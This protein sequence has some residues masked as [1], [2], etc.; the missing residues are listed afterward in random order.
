MGRFMRSVRHRCQLKPR[1]TRVVPTHST[2]L[3]QF[4]NHPLLTK[5]VEATIRDSGL[6]SV[7]EQLNN[8][9]SAQIPSDSGI[10]K[11]EK[12]KKDSETVQC[13]WLL[14]VV[15]ILLRYGCC[16][17]PQNPEQEFRSYVEEE[18]IWVPRPK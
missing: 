17:S 16:F 18:M 6:V 12:E 2:E 7:F 11:K 15:S 14:S 4:Q 10:E 13:N 5:V 8:I 3:G 1:F 9:S